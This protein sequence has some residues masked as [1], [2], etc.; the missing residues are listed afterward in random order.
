MLF[1]ATVFFGFSQECIAVLI[2]EQV[3]NDPGKVEL[4][5]RDAKLITNLFIKELKNK[6]IEVVSSP[7]AD[8]K[9]EAALAIIEKAAKADMANYLFIEVPQQMLKEATKATV[10]IGQIL[11]AGDPSGII[12]EIEKL[13]TEKAKEYLINW[14]YQNRIKINSGELP[15]SYVDLNNNWHNL[16]LPY[17]IAFKGLDSKIASVSIGIYSSKTLKTAVP[18]R[19]FQWEGGIEDLPPF[20]LK[21][22]GLVEEKNGGYGWI[23]T[24]KIEVIFNE[25]VPEFSF[26][27][28]T[29]W[30]KIK[31]FFKD[32]LPDL[33][34]L[35]ANVGDEL[36]LLETINSED[37]SVVDTSLFNNTEEEIQE[38]DN[39]DIY[40]APKITENPEPLESPKN[41][42]DPMTLEEIEELLNDI[43]E[44]VNDLSGQINELAGGIIEDEEEDNDEKAKDPVKPKTQPKYSSGGGST[45]AP[46]AYCEKAVEVEAESNK[47]IINE[48]AWMGT[49]VS[50]NDEWIELKNI[51]ND[52]IN[53]SGWQITDKE[54]Q[55]KIVFGP[56]DEIPGGG[57]YLLE[58]TDDESVPHI[59]ADYIYSGSLNDSNES[60][61]LFDN[62]C[63]VQD[64]A[65]AEPDWPNG[66]KEEKRTMERASD[67][68]W[69]TYSGD[70]TNNILGT[71]LAENSQ[72]FDINEVD[73]TAK[74]VVISEVQNSDNE[75]IE[76]FNPTN[77]NIDMSGWYFSYFSSERDWNSPW[78]N[79][80]FPAEAQILSGGYYLIGLK[81]YP[82]I[83]GNPEADWQPYDNA[84]LSDSSGSIV[85]FPFDPE[86]K[87]IEEAEQGKID[88]LG[89]GSVKVKEGESASVPDQNKSCARKQDILSQLYIDSDINKEDFETKDISPT[90]SKGETIYNLSFV[91]SPWPMYQGNAG[92]NGQGLFSGPISQP[93]IQWVYSD[94]EDALYSSP[95]IDDNNI[96]YTSVI[97]SD[98]K[99]I[100]SL[101]PNGTK[102]FFENKDISLALKGIGNEIVPDDKLSQA[103]GEDGSFYY[104]S[105]NTL[106][107]F[108]KDSVLKWDKKFEKSEEECV[109]AN[110]QPINPVVGKD[111]MIYVVIR[112]KCCNSYGDRNDY[113]YIIS[114]DG[115]IIQEID[116]MGFG[117]N[118][119]AVSL[120]GASYFINAH[121]GKYSVGSYGDLKAFSQT[122]EC[123]WRYELWNDGDSSPYSY[124]IVDSLGNVFII[125][126]KT[127]LAFDKNGNNLW[128]LLIDIEPINWNTTTIGMALSS[129]GTIYI[130][131][132]GA[133][134]AVR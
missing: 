131:G 91:N 30:D 28:Q 109:Q 105:G 90:N 19:N 116:A 97:S 120:D 100:L 134:I 79:M 6:W 59:S 58:R 114:P 7:D 43:A 54:K 68:T 99:G 129:D 25:P 74:S 123:I 126:D 94:E 46:I 124:P 41:N 102:R 5:E 47:V 3:I 9:E 117:T 70:G 45:Q 98:K 37:N 108:D 22:R 11:L 83:Y 13:T 88:A 10:K 62:L 64:E 53:L 95:I 60:L 96:I 69:Q 55:I 12:G 71:P 85:I 2:P 49:S 56:G 115:G 110:P 111:G 87:E 52:P 82:E 42:P 20:I 104:T 133:I 35:R 66:D 38:E 77:E 15:L 1:S 128:E 78:K 86:T 113:Y 33:S 80:Q 84:V 29:I 106:F 101:N 16:S 65:L 127:L 8:L 4:K 32:L 17:I 76:L 75:F 67:L 63:Q 107:A 121:Y 39:D 125:Y 93:M 14:L 72:N 27:K 40:Q 57:F 51:T 112:D 92:R 44:K 103:E 89:W 24:P 132:K 26:P 31:D 18:R 21:V 23:G 61:Y 34:F 130:S 122:G 73:N 50:S 81:G 48:I 119:P 36:R 118:L